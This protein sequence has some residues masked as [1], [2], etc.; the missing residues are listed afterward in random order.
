MVLCISPKIASVRFI[1]P[2]CFVE[3]HSYNSWS[4][5]TVCQSHSLPRTLHTSFFKIF[6]YFFVLSF[7]DSRDIFFLLLYRWFVC[8]FSLCC[9]YSITS[10]HKINSKIKRND[11]QAKSMY[12]RFFVQ[13]LFFSVA[14]VFL[15]FIFGYYSMLL[16]SI[17]FLISFIIS[18]CQC[19]SLEL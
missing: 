4:S 16:N 2:I 9:H 12:F 5:G 15:N 19:L 6:R 7:S 17:W 13:M 8:A 11:E 18:S 1:Y 3:F 14:L 10:M